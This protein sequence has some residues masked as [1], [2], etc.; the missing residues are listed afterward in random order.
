LPTGI[1]RT[2]SA[3]REV[4][5]A[6]PALDEEDVVGEARKRAPMAAFT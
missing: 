4:S 5:E 6:P 2:A 1:L 3:L